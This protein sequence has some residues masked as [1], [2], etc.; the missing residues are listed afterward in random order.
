MKDAYTKLMAQQHTSK[1]AAF[2]EKLEN[3]TTKKR[4][5]VWKTAIA[6]A[7][8]LLTIPVTVWAAENIFG[9]T[10]I[11]QFKGTNFQGI[12]SI[13]YAAQ[14]ENVENIPITEF[15]S[16][17]QELE[18]PELAYFDSWEEAEQ[19]I[20]IDLISNNILTGEGTNPLKPFYTGKKPPLAHIQGRYQTA[21]GQL[22]SVIL[23]A[24]YY[25]NKTRFW[26]SA[27]MTADNP[28]MTEEM[29]QIYHGFGMR[30]YPAN[31]TDG[32]SVEQYTTENGIPVTIVFP[33]NNYSSA[34][35]F[36]SVNNISYHVDI[37]GYEIRNGETKEMAKERA[38][39][40]LREVLE[41]FA[42]E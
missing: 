40:V 5:P 33:I 1:D 26:V 13:G 37:C 34:E 35:A 14:V 2:Y 8:I 32:F 27:H 28:Q 4:K 12:D 24:K 7:C 36:F 42:L 3:G 17:L 6:A 38:L 18:E 22:F 30:Y 11:E 21:D 16:Y 20:G 23:D 29:F 25:R 41:G 39:D 19:T 31:K 9:I 10:L 15:S